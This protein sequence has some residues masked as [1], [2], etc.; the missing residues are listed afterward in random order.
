MSIAICPLPP[1]Q[2]QAK[3]DKWSLICVLKSKGTAYPANIKANSFREGPPPTGMP[4][5]LSQQ[6][7]K[8]TASDVRGPP[9]T[10]MA[11]QLS[12]Q[13]LKPTASDGRGPPHTGM[14]T[15]PGQR[16]TIL[17]KISQRCHSIRESNRMDTH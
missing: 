15:R 16:Q 9:H 3:P 12:Q 17:A 14:A 8:P 11:T 4:T 5:Q 6:I 2:S 1:P 7:L 13:I 10:G